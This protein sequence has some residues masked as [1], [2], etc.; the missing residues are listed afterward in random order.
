VFGWAKPVPYNPIH[1]KDP[2]NGAGKIAVSGPLSNLAIAVIFGVLV[3]T[4]PLFGIPADSPLFMLFA[5]ISYINVLLAIFNLVPIPPL[6]GSKVLF[7]ILPNT[8]TTMR[9][10]IFLE[11]Y[12]MIFLLIFVFFG[13]SLISPIVRWLFSAIT[14]F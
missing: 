3:R 14:G 12:G 7:S 13:F 8:E 1:L 2:K 9:L 10:G 5:Y 11:R 4:L 6:D